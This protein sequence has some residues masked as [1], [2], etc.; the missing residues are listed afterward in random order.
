[1]NKVDLYKLEKYLKM[2]KSD[3]DYNISNIRSRKTEVE[4][5]FSIFSLHYGG[6]KGEEFARNWLQ[7]DDWLNDYIRKTQELARFLE[8]SATILEKTNI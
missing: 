1:M 5:A 4:E 6:E 2:F 7:A 3:L 8:E